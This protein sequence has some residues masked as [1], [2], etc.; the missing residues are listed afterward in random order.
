MDPS[1]NL[2]FIPSKVMQTWTERA[3]IERRSRAVIKRHD[4]HADGASAPLHACVRRTL[5]LTRPAVRGPSWF[6]GGELE[7]RLHCHGNGF[8]GLITG[9]PKFALDLKTVGQGRDTAG[10]RFRVK[11]VA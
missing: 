10:G 6:G 8:G 4:R 11:V 1:R 5:D 3:I 7:K 2:P 9:E